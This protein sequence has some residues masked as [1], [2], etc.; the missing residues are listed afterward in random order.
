MQIDNEYATCD[1]LVHCLY[2]QIGDTIDENNWQVLNQD[3]CG[4]D[5]TPGYRYVLS[6]KRNKIGTN[7]DGK[8]IYEYCLNNVISKTKVY[9]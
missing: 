6:V 5:Y 4:F 8:K 9:L 3:I 2:Y 1:S 7:D